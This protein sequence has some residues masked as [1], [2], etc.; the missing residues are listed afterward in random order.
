MADN[1]KKNE[2][3][4]NNQ[5]G[6]VDELRDVAAQMGISPQGNTKEFRELVVDYIQKK[7]VGVFDMNSTTA[8]QLLGKPEATAEYQSMLDE[9]FTA[10][11]FNDAESNDMLKFASTPDKMKE[12][13][14][15]YFRKSEN[16]R[17][18]QKEYRGQGGSSTSEKAA[19]FYKKTAKE[20]KE[21]LAKAKENAKNLTDV[22]V[23]NKNA[24]TKEENATTNENVRGLND[25]IALM[26]KWKQKERNLSE[27]EK[28][29]TGEDDLKKLA[30]ELKKIQKEIKAIKEMEDLELSIDNKEK[31]IESKKSSL[32]EGEVEEK[33]LSKQHALVIA[34]KA[35]LENDPE[36][37][38]KIDAFV[39]AE[40]EHKKMSSFLDTTKEIKEEESSKKSLQSKLDDLSKANPELASLDDA[41]ANEKNHISKISKIK[42]IKELTK[43]LSTPRKDI[44]SLLERHTKSAPIPLTYASA[45]QE[46]LE[47]LK[48]DLKQKA[49][50]DSNTLLG[51]QIKS[52]EILT[53]EDVD[54]L[55][56]AIKDFSETPGSLRINQSEFTQILNNNPGFKEK[57]FELDN[58]EIQRFLISSKELKDPQASEG[59]EEFGEDHF[60][61][62]K[63]LSIGER[64]ALQLKDYDHKDPKKDPLFFDKD[65]GGDL[66]PYKDFENITQDDIDTFMDDAEKGDNDVDFLRRYVI[67]S[68]ITTT[69]MMDKD[70][71]ADAGSTILKNINSESV[72]DRLSGIVGLEN[73]SI[74]DVKDKF[75]S[76]GASGSKGKFPPII[77]TSVGE[78]LG[79]YENSQLSKTRNGFNTEITDKQLYS[80]RDIQQR[81]ADIKMIVKDFHWNGRTKNLTENEKAILPVWLQDGLVALPNIKF[82]DPD[83][84]ALYEKLYGKTEAVGSPGPRYSV[85]I[86]KELYD[87]ES[88]FIKKHKDLLSQEN[89]DD[90]TTDKLKSY[91]LKNGVIYKKIDENEVKLIESIPM[92]DTD[93]ARDFS[94][95]IYD[96]YRYEGDDEI[97]F[98]TGQLIKGLVD[99]VEPAGWN[100]FLDNVDSPSIKE[101][102]SDTGLDEARA[103]EIIGNLIKEPDFN[104][105]SS[106]DLKI[107]DYLKIQHSLEKKKNSPLYRAT[108]PAL[109][110]IEKNIDQMKFRLEFSNEMSSEKKEGSNQGYSSSLV[111]GQD[112]FYNSIHKMAEVEADSK[113]VKT[114]AQKV[115]TDKHDSL[116]SGKKGFSGS[117]SQIGLALQQKLGIALLSK[118][119]EDYSKGSDDFLAIIQTIPQGV[120]LKAKFAVDNSPNATDNVSKIVD[121]LRKYTDGKKNPVLTEGTMTHIASSGLISLTSNLTNLHFSNATIDKNKLDEAADGMTCE[122]CPVKK[123]AFIAAIIK[124]STSSLYELTNEELTILSVP[125]IVDYLKSSDEEGTSTLPFLTGDTRAFLNKINA[126]DTASKDLDSRK[127]AITKNPIEAKTDQ[128]N[129]NV[130]VAADD[131]KRKQLLKDQD[132]ADVAFNEEKNGKWRNKQVEA[133]KHNIQKYKKLSSKMKAN[134]ETSVTVL[135]ESWKTPSRSMKPVLAGLVRGA[136]NALASLVKT[137]AT[138]EINDGLT[139]QI[140]GGLLDQIKVVSGNAFNKFDYIKNNSKVHSMIPDSWLE[141]FKKQE[142]EKDNQQL[143]SIAAYSEMFED[144]QQRKTALGAFAA[145]SD[146]ID[147]TK[148]KPAYPAKYGDE[149]INNFV[150]GAKSPS[151]YLGE[152]MDS[153]NGNS[154]QPDFVKQI[155]EGMGKSS[156]VKPWEGSN[157]LGLGPLTSNAKKLM[158]EKIKENAEQNKHKRRALLASSV[159]SIS[160]VDKDSNATKPVD[161]IID[162][163]I[164]ASNEQ[165]GCLDPGDLEGIV[166]AL[167]PETPEGKDTPSLI[168]ELKEIKEGH[169]KIAE[170]HTRTV[171]VL[172]NDNATNTNISIMIDVNGNY[173]VTGTINK[174]DVRSPSQVSGVMDDLHDGRCPDELKKVLA[175]V[176][177]VDI[178]TAASHDPDKLRS[179]LTLIELVQ[180][181]EKNQNPQL[182]NSPELYRNIL[183]NI[184]RSDA[185]ETQKMAF[186]KDIIE[187]KYITDQNK[188]DWKPVLEDEKLRASKGKKVTHDSWSEEDDKTLRNEAAEVSYH[189]ENP[190]TKKRL[191]QEF[192]K[193]LNKTEAEIESQ[194]EVQDRN[195]LQKAYHGVVDLEFHS[196]GALFQSSNHGLSVTQ[197]ELLEEVKGYIN[198]DKIEQAKDSLRILLVGVNEYQREVVANEVGKTKAFVDVSNEKKVAQKKSRSR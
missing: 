107:N 64:L 117:G 32:P 94:K 162:N 163:I 30:E 77:A 75:Q 137:G 79:W 98:S 49:N 150:A 145:S 119:E 192:A 184:Y 88:E 142:K 105:H 99:K 5:I 37:P 24:K 196:V 104:F 8:T 25:V 166:K 161:K 121:V 34:A 109:D 128:R 140:Q 26:K 124:L 176:N 195:I 197:K 185:G 40:V 174:E 50:I 191:N 6:I 135:N 10:F 110:S 52:K 12:M 122:T 55:V 100:S 143:A 22:L 56:D 131:V 96:Q 189:K 132:E 66:H 91:F 172:K 136:G 164:A 87:P 148:M 17:E 113:K 95:I 58:P 35:L 16:F 7:A 43:E 187:G 129:M 36:D 93:L 173:T 152:A 54:I 23:I 39:K 118:S 168:K 63:N 42:S 27:L 153:Y 73:S 169:A 157:P 19:G 188:D 71:D 193:L 133:D 125:S 70:F 33:D 106:P 21:A 59:D 103:R 116:M 160:P 31:S 112:G 78:S 28:D 158:R 61:E 139:P 68:S 57:V 111:I 80:M 48:K 127:A 85:E 53:E 123:D 76:L 178:I 4:D 165:E 180:K 1:N 182:I 65:K 194:L 156:E 126:I 92:F 141:D 38:E 74:S 155:R 2:V 89:T 47:E 154:Y 62:E 108:Y 67:I 183:R 20:E 84:T 69:A 9:A 101:V 44:D 175:G 138:G 147:F 46:G 190:E 72:L 171:E 115:K 18:I 13:D 90:D 144:M 51:T 81:T 83:Q 159:S 97:N 41:E 60:Y 198:Q 167:R 120:L 177:A 86:I 170:Q 11:E 102:V 186:V 151:F 14:E 181:Q 146:K 45:T 29:I 114:T 15:K 3:Q 82:N 149:A 179:H 134:S 130:A